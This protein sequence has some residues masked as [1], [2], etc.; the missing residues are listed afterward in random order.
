MI[1]ILALIVVGATV[2]ALRRRTGTRGDGGDLPSHVVATAA[3][4]LPA[5]RLEW[6]QAMIGELSAIHGSAAR[7]RFAGAAVRVAILPPTRHSGTSATLAGTGLAGT[8]VATLAAERFV[9]T[10]GVFVATLG[11]LLTASAIALAGRWRSLPTGR[12]ARVAGAVA[13]S[14][15]LA[16]TCAVVAVATAD[17]GAT[18]DRTHLA[19]LTLAATL[20]GYVVGGLAMARATGTPSAVHGVAV[21]GAA[22]AA[23]SGTALDI[24]K[25]LGVIQ[26]ISPTGTVATAATAIVVAA[27]TGSR[28][29]GR[30]A[31]LLSA[32]LG[33]PVQ[34]AATLL[35][36]RGTVPSAILADSLAGDIVRLAITPLAMYVIAALSVVVVR[37]PT[38]LGKPLY[39]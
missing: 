5:H 19:S 33:A 12:G 14:G 3:R 7:W 38:D 24:Y 31:G 35:L 17:P 11:L 26:L 25:S 22:V 30:R 1:I 15:L 10:L 29:A 37:Q 39:Q 18:Q 21:A 27:A 32:V 6:G 13:G 2:A 20:C 4:W 34:F 16:A 36:L 9:P 23:S 8:V 28:A